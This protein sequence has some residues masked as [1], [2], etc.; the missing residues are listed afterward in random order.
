MRF[1][2]IGLVLLAS[3]AMPAM[4]QREESVDRRLDRIEQELRAVQ[5]RVFPGANGPVL[6][7]EMEA[8]APAPPAAGVPAT[9]PAPE[10]RTGRPNVLKVTVGNTAIPPLGPPETMVKNVSLKPADLFARANGT[11]TPS[12]APAAAAVPA[13]AHRTAAARPHRAPTAAAV[14]EA[15][16]A[17][18]PT[19]APAPPPAAPPATG[20][21][22]TQ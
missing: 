8:P 2:L 1:H 20:A 6:A 3:V 11:P 18:A 22:P 14:P 4:A 5:R 12:G 9:A 21:P 19:A 7:P 17:P 10:I 15:A 16:P 13:P